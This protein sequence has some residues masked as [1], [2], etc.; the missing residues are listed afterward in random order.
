MVKFKRIYFCTD[1][2]RNVLEAR[3]FIVGNWTEKEQADVAF[4]IGGD[5]WRVLVK[6]AL[7]CWGLMVS[8]AWYCALMEISFENTF[9][10]LCGPNIPLQS[11]FS[12]ALNWILKIR[13][14]Y[15]SYTC[16]RLGIWRI[17]VCCWY[18][19]E[20]L[21]EMRTRLIAF[22]AWSISPTT[23]VGVAALLLLIPFFECAVVW[24]EAMK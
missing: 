6:Q 20:N 16:T 14:V 23:Y 1:L 17:R 12:R 10:W 13:T 4:D 8:G 15:A 11:R 5:R 7:G 2:R 9:I 21:A 19:D 18:I 22:S 3:W 24:C